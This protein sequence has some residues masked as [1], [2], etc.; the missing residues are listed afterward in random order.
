MRS[1]VRIL[2]AAFC[3]AGFGIGCGKN[4]PSEETKMGVPVKADGKGPKKGGR[5]GMPIP[6][7][8]PP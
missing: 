5:G 7:P 1:W 6:P 4:A 8:P 3:L 2:F